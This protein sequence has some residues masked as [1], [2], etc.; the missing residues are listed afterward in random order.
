MK[1][2]I[3]YISESIDGNNELKVNWQSL[4]NNEIL[5]MKLIPPKRSP[6]KTAYYKGTMR[7]IVGLL[8]GIALQFGDRIPN[9]LKDLLK[10]YEECRKAMKG[11]RG[12][13]AVSTQAEYE[14][15]EKNIQ[16]KDYSK[17]WQKCL[18]KETYYRKIGD[19]LGLIQIYK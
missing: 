3:N 6:L 10:Y 16:Q 18:N 17:K 1:N 9:N 11:F 2:L 12:K 8:Y 14:D 13:F 4:N 19:T 15:A 7:Q 5:Y